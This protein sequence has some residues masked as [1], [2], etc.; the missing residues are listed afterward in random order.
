L[1]RLF[2]DAQPPVSVDDFAERPW[3]ASFYQGRQYGFPLDVHPIGLYYNTRLFEQAGVVD[4]HRRALPPVDWASFFSGAQ[5]L[6]GATDGDGRPD[7]WGFVFTLQRSNWLTFA[8]QFGA[9]V[10]TPD[11]RACDMESAGNLE[12][13]RHMRALI[14]Q[15][16]V[17]PKP[18]GIDAWL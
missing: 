18:E 9:D 8:G 5:K 13:L 3:K 15:D 2:A 17:T 16:H 6:T 4:A 1:E 10:L 12:A 7:Q 11:L 14:Y